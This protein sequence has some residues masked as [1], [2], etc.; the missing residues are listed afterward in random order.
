MK[1]AVL[2]LGWEFP[3]HISGGL[4]VATF[5]ICQA[6]AD[7]ATLSVLVPS[8]EHPQLTGIQFIPP[9]SEAL[10]TPLPLTRFEDWASS[11]APQPLDPYQALGVIAPAPEKTRKSSFPGIDASTTLY[12]EDMADQIRQ[13]IQ[14]GAQW[15][16]SQPFDL[17]HAHDWMTLPAAM[18]IKTLTGKPLV[19]HIH[20]I[21]GDRRAQHPDPQIFEIERAA[22]KMADRII[23]V[24][25]FTAKE[26]ETTYGIDPEK[27]AVIHNGIRQVA[28]YRKERAFPEKLVVFLGRMTHQKG[29]DL[30][31][32]IAEHTLASWPSARFVMIGK[33]EALGES[34]TL[35][36]K[37]GLGDKIHFTGFL[38]EASVHEILSMAD[39]F[40][41]TSR[42][43]PFGLV[44]LEAAQFGIPCLISSRSG[45]KEVLPGA[46]VLDPEAPDAWAKRLTLLFSDPSLQ[47]TLVSEIKE[48]LG[49]LSWSQ[50]A[51]KIR[52]VYAS[53]LE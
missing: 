21:E 51:K 25:A 9:K 7:H 3:P 39:A 46:I 42:S 31:I 13:Y 44:A 16:L 12:A 32:R 48:D 49:Q 27:I 45:V 4:G 43:E 18:E 33:G 5:E 34:I 8:Q 6:L 50:N 47:E 22:L 19:V 29:P 52:E 28:A 26:I 36:A 24:S 40:L 35:A 1:P 11:F 14:T 17:I 30:F 53:L 37:L 38:P 23:A 20:S 2:F 15:S 10:A 41:L